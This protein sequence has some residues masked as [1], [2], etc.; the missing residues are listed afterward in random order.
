VLKAPALYVQD[1]TGGAAVQP[2]SSPALKIGDEVEVVGSAET[3]GFS[4]VLKNARVRLLWEATP[5]PPLS[6]TANQAATGAYDAMFIQVEGYLENKWAAGKSAL[7]LNLEMGPQTFRALINPGRSA[8]RLDRLYSGSLLRLGG[9][10]VTNSKYT[11]NETPFLL[12]VRSTEDLQVIAGP[13]WWSLSTLIPFAIGL[14]ILAAAAYNLYILAKHWRLRAVVE[15]RSRLAHE[16]HDTLAQ[17]FAGIGFQLEAI[18]NSMPAHA[19]QLEQQVDLACDLVRHSHEEARRSIATLRPESLE[20]AGLAPALKACADRMIQYGPVSV[21][22]SVEG[23]TPAIPLRIKDTLFR[24][25]QEAI[26]NAIR[27][28]KAETIYVHVRH[29]RS[30][31]RL[32]VEDDGIGFVP[33]SGSHGFGLIGMRRRAASISAEMNVRSAPGGGTKVEVI[34]P[35]PARFSVKT[36]LKGILEQSRAHAKREHTYSY[37]G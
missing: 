3:H 37:R 35:L 20:S 14:L 9:I 27:H 30:A 12:L 29:E 16:I 13:P 6:V 33:Q 25:G 19:P 4:S 1:S 26:A 23:S 32:R 22:A 31:V 18:R 7:V 34:A 2:V 8:S 24:I 17:S 21:K 15:E 36:W 28:A 5:G 11:N 10:C